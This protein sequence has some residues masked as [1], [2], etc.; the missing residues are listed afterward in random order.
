MEI[1]V[2][3]VSKKEQRMCEALHQFRSNRAFVKR[4]TN[5]LN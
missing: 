4:S 3:N 1:V 2:E 5:F